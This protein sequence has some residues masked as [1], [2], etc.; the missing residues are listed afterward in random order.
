MATFLPN[1]DVFRQYINVVKKRRRGKFGLAR[2]ISG[3]VHNEFL[4]TSR[5]TPSVG[6]IRWDIAPLAPCAQNVQMAIRHLAFIDLPLA[7]TA[8]GWRDEV[9]QG[10][11]SL[12]KSLG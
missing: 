11:S 8:L 3:R 2:G 5:R 10:L 6:Q 4:A 7:A 12:V 1:L 9:L